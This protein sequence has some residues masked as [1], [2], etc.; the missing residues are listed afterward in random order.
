MPQLFISNQEQQF[1]IKFGYADQNGLTGI[2]IGT[3]DLIIEF[4]IK[5]Y[6]Q[7]AAFAKKTGFY[8]PTY[9]T[10][11]NAA[12]GHYVRIIKNVVSG[13]YGEVVDAGGVLFAQA[14]NIETMFR[15]VLHVFFIVRATSGILFLNGHNIRTT[16]KVAHNIASTRLRLFTSTVVGGLATPSI[17]CM[18]RMYVGDLSG[19]TDAQLLA[20]HRKYLQIPF[21]RIPELNPYLKF[22]WEG[23]QA[24]ITPG[25]IGLLIL[26]SA[27]NLQNAINGENLA[28]NAGTWGSVK[29]IIWTPR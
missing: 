24:D 17:G 1:G 6:A 29:S 26:D 12:L 23:R 7:D 20:I 16:V 11:G 14:Y 25:I 28:L 22:A 5:E 9:L 13:I 4:L 15:D 2:S 10:I 3:S 19:F 8:L 18:A 21:A 27:T